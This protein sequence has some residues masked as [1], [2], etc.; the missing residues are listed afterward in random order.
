MFIED[1]TFERKREEAELGR[2]AMRMKVTAGP[3]KCSRAKLVGRGQK[4]QYHTSP[5][6]CI[7]RGPALTIQFFL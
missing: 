3:M 7:G 6:S 4:G 5:H 2:G 1:E